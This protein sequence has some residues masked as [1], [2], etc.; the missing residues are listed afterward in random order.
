MT[1]ESSYRTDVDP[2]WQGAGCTSCHGSSGGLSLSGTADDNWQ[3][4]VHD[5]AGGGPRVNFADIP[6]SDILCRG[7]ATAA[8]GCP[9]GTGTKPFATTSDARYRAIFDW[10]SQGAKNN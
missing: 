5:E 3:E 4:I 9:H 6:A 7:L 10:I 8:G 1:T 2:I